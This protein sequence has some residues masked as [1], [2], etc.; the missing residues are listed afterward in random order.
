LP[1]GEVGEIAIRG[2]NIMKGY[3]GNPRA[4]A[5][6]LDAEGWF[7]SGDL[8]VVEPDGAVR[9]VGRLKD[10]IIRGGVNIYPR[11]IEDLLHEHPAVRAAAV[12]GVPDER[13]GEEVGAAIVLEEGVQA[14]AEELRD[15]VRARVA[16]HKYPRHVWFE[17]K[18]PLG[19]TGKVLKREI[20]RPEQVACAR[21]ETPS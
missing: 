19:P 4:T 18:L 3:W 11:E 2:H 1:P 17:A 21:E 9:I 8:G 12:V 7:Y 15:W 20:T 6:A 16:P 14:S 13:L 10:M 5:D